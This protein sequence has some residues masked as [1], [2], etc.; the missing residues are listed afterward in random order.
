MS[1]LPEEMK[2]KQEVRLLHIN[3]WSVAKGGG[4]KNRHSSGAGV[5]LL[6]L[7]MFE[8]YTMEFSSHLGQFTNTQ[9]AQS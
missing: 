7:V 8:E 4:G 2:L 9:R 1:A 5:L 6:L 3:C